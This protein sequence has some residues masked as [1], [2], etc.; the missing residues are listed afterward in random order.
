MCPLYKH[1]RA[2]LYEQIIVLPTIDICS[3]LNGH[4]MLSPENNI[5]I[6]Y[7]LI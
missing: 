5:T 1:H 7:I 3:L 4:E 2:I 6:Y